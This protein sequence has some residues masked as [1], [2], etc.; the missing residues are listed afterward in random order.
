MGLKLL[1]YFICGGSMY[2]P[3][4]GMYAYN[5]EK[6]EK[7][8]GNCEKVLKKMITLTHLIISEYPP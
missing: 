2:P 8:H 7:L 6:G 4:P 5:G 3:F 1:H